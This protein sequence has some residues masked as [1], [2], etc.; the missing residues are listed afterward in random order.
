MAIP[1]Q[2]TA[3]QSSGLIPTGQLW[4]PRA[5]LAA[6]VRGALVRSTLG[7]AL[8]DEQRISR[9]P[10]SPLCSLNWWFEGRGEVLV[11]EGDAMPG[12]G[13]MREPMPGRWVLAGPQTRPVSSWCPGPA[14]GMMVLF[15]PDALHWLTGLEPSELADRFVD[16]QGVL[17]RDWLDMCAAVQR[18]PSDAERLVCLEDFLEP[19]WQSRRPAWPLQAQRYADWAMHL[20]HRAAMSA[21]GRSLR[22]LERRIKRW[23][24]LPLRELRGFGRAERA[25]FDAAATLEVKGGV[26]WAAVAASAGFSDQPHL[27]R[28]TRRIT[29]YTPQALFEGMQRDEAFWVYRVWS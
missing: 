24:G 26:P 20:A 9:F 17:P 23:A 6:C 5:S 21:P 2:R 28:V 3:R 13:A 11:A 8:S 25:F 14:H 4:L 7:F 16:A 12:V 18:L 10:A 29:G 27:C 22:Q 15:M 19:R 1:I